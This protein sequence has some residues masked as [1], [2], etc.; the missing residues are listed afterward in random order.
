MRKAEALPFPSDY[1]LVCPFCTC[2]HHIVWGLTQGLDKVCWLFSVS[3]SRFDEAGS[4]AR[5]AWAKCRV[6]Q[7]KLK[8]HNAQWLTIAAFSRQKSISGQVTVLSM[9]LTCSPCTWPFSQSQNKQ[10]W[11]IVY[12]KL[13][14][15]ENVNILVCL[16]RLALWWNVKNHRIC[17]IEYSRISWERRVSVESI[18]TKMVK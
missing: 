1:F 5:A 11:L 15:N 7:I 16:Y 10:T 17:I 4:C 12:A 18:W 6:L 3:R 2:A 13:S 9:G 8:P 14:L